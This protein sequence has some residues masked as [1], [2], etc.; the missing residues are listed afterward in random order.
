MVSIKNLGVSKLATSGAVGSGQGR[1]A[2]LL[3]EVAQALSTA[4]GGEATSVCNGPS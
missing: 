3:L 2:D 1:G 4:R